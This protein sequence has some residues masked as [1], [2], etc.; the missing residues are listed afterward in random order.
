MSAGASKRLKPRT[1][2]LNQQGFEF[3][4]PKARIASGERQQVPQTDGS[5]PP[6]SFL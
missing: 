2:D 6:P 3:Q 4:K 5:T 1:A